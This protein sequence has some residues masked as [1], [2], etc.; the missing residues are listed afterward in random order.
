MV[1]LGRPYHFKIFKGCLPQILLGLFLNTLPH[2]ISS[3]VFQK[4][5]EIIMDKDDLDKDFE[6]KYIPND[7]LP[8]CKRN[9]TDKN[10]DELRVPLH[11]NMGTECMVDEEN[12]LIGDASFSDTI[13]IIT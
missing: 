9:F 2:L 6:Q 8:N 4:D 7:A 13:P 10:F 11:A 3:M 12:S 5:T 1:C